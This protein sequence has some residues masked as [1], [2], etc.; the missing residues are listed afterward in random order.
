M[1]Y[2]RLHV[3]IVVLA[4]VAV[5]GVCLSAALTRLFPTGQP[6]RS[7]IRY[8]EWMNA[9]ADEAKLK[10]IAI[11]A[12]HNT[13]SIDCTLGTTS[14]PL[15]WLDCQQDT[16]Y[17]QL[18]YGVR[19]LDLRTGYD[20]KSD[21]VY[22]VHGTGFGIPL[23]DALRDLK[24]FDET[25]PGQFY[26]VSISV[27]GVVQGAPAESMRDLI[28]RYLPAERVFPADT[29]LTDMTIGAMRATGKTFVL[30]TDPSW[31]IENST[32][33]MHD[34]WTGAANSGR[35]DDNT[36][37]FLHLEQELRSASDS[38]LLL[39]SFNR[40][41]GDSLAKELPLDFMLADRAAFLELI[42]QIESN[43]QFLSR[44]NFFN[45][46]YTTYDWIQCASVIG[47][48]LTKNLVRPESRAAFSALIEQRLA[49]SD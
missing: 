34:T 5:I 14:I 30:R 41:S 42:D 7:Q 44:A 1:K 20:P 39:L 28:G 37:L 27:Y 33:R 18:R 15:R 10:E 11:P 40:G 13:G 49:E 9:I 36:A 48:N 22:C 23:E 43:R 3:L 2:R 47:L 31:G 45:F 8:E 25:Y 4:T 24:R 35:T 26:F 46:D 16:V 29:D 32:Y 6:D 38:E 12:S 17:D 19:L 21:I